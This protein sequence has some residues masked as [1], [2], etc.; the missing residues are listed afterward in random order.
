MRGK[1]ASFPFYASTKYNSIPPAMTNN[2]NNPS[3]APPV[4]F[5]VT[6]F[7]PFHNARENPTT[8]IANRLV[9]YLKSKEEEAATLASRTRTLIIQTSAQAARSALDEIVQPS[10]N[11][12]TTIVYLHLGV[13]YK[14]TKF[15][16][17]QC[18]YNDASFRIPDE[19]GYQ[20]R[21]VCIVKDVS[22]GSSLETN[23]NLENICTLLDSMAPVTVSTDPGRF[24]CNYTYFYS[25][26]KTQHCSNVYSLFVHVPP[27]AVVP[28]QEQMKVLVAI[29]QCIDNQLSDT[30]TVVA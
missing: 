19:Q 17:E 22:L 2:G 30:I 24:V 11:T 27:F 8:I 3:N 5:L 16:L 15:Q 23:L 9:E 29:M 10:S 6:G 1:E 14:G 26:H 18:A 20:P 12:T 13:N 25:L 21:G 7:G 28:E 4:T